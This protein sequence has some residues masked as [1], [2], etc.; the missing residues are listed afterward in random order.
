MTTTTT[1]ET[2]TAPQWAIIELMGH[3]RYGGQVSKD[4]QFGTAMLRVD[5]PQTD[6]SFVSQLV[7][8]SSIYRITMCTEEIARVAARQGD[9]KPLSEWSLKHLLPPGETTT[10]G[11]PPFPDYSTTD[12]EDFE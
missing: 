4:N 7:N 8:P 6:G 3:I 10:A 1:P 12:A 9:S 2:E 5:V 11:A